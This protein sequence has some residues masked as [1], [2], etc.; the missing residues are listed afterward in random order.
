MSARTT[1]YSFSLSTSERAVHHA[2]CAYLYGRLHAC[3]KQYGLSL[4]ELMVALVISSLILLGLVQIFSSTRTTYQVDEGLARLQENGRFAMD[5]LVRD[6][7]MAG[8]MGCLGK[9]PTSKQQQNVWNYLISP[10]SG[11]DLTRG[12]IGFEM[13]GTAPG[14]SYSLP[15]QY[16][17]A[18]TTA[19]TPALD[20]TLIPSAAMGSDVVAVRFMDGVSTPLVPN[21]SGK[22]H[23]SAQ[24]FAG[25]PNNLSQN[26]VVMVTNCKQVAIF[27]IT[28]TPSGGSPVNVAHS[29]AGNI[30]PNWGTG[31]CKGYDNAFGA[32]SQIAGLRSVVFFVSA[33][34]SN[35]NSP[36]LFRQDIATPMPAAVELVEGIEN[37]QV[38]Y[39]VDT[40]N[41]FPKH[42]ADS[43]VTADQI[44]LN[45]ETGLPDWTRV[46]SV[47]LGLLVSTSNVAGQADTSLDTSTYTVAGVTLDPAVDDRRRR[48]VFSATVGLRNQ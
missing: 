13:P 16:P 25:A 18:L 42:N 33:G 6:I 46:V 31:G 37:M 36:A 3:N 23:D 24:V 5:F 22:Y 27:K 2:K 8:N 26:Q 7:R 20:T 9:I 48:R 44:P 40:D 11:F 12:I 19:T 29:S 45:P 30:C 47:R 10:G 28:N 1:M 39:G 43:Y 17:P 34:A 41:D 38:L 4:I 14:A 21:A 35:P 32:G 15:L